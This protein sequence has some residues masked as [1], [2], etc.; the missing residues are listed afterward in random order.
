MNIKNALANVG[1]TQKNLLID[2]AI[3]RIAISDTSG[4]LSTVEINDLIIQISGKVGLL[5]DREKLGVITDALSP[6]DATRLCRS[7][8]LESES[9]PWGQLRNQKIR[10]NSQMERD[11]FGWFEISE[12]DF[13]AP[14]IVDV[15]PTLELIQPVHGLFLHQRT[16]IQQVR[17]LLNSNHPRAF[18]HMPTGSGKTRTAMNYICESLASKK[19]GLVV[20]FAFNGELCEQAAKEF[21]KAW[22]YHGNRDISIQRMWGS[23]SV[24]E[25]TDDGILL[26]GLDKL[27]AKMRQDNVW[28]YNLAHRVDLLVFDEAHQS[29]AETYQHMVEILLDGNSTKLL[30]LSATPGRTYN[31]PKDDERL[32][33][34]YYRQK[35]TL[36]VEGYSSPL[37]YLIDENYLSKPIFNQMSSDST[38]LTK[39][40][41]QRLIASDDYSTSI[42]EKLSD[43]EIRNLKILD[44]V[45]ILVN[46]GHKRILVFANSVRHSEILNAYTELRTDIR[47]SSITASTAPDKRQ[48]WL[49]LFKDASDEEACVLFNYGVLTTGFDAPR[50][51]AAII[52]RPTKSLVLYSQM[53]GRVIRGTKVDGTESAEIWTVVDQGLPGFRDLSEAFNNWED[54]W[55]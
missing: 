27:W 1:D 22:S 24:D 51:S 45:K 38:T 25:V 55:D 4:P 9:G 15:Q 53:V 19:K 35:V 48:K 28:L 7:L 40:E 39:N 41:L 21:I 52:S 10:K 33:D 37:N 23:H 5:R 13:P 44:R 46:E 34:L 18:L 43:D 2:Q 54:V 50:T 26:V 14:I 8:G 11:L 3:L 47:S 42:L 36:E 12:S 6:K 30:G 17:T 20:W 49:E 16:A 31:D 29:T 32:S